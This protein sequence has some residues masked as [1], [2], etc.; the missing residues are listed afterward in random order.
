MSATIIMLVRLALWIF[1][2]LGWA[3]NLAERRAGAAQSQLEATNAEI[4]RIN[5]AANAANSLPIDTPDPYDR[6]K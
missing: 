6:D 5:R 1:K 4:D 3:S 2:A